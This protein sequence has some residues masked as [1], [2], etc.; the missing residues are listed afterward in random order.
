M[1]TQLAGCLVSLLVFAAAAPAAGQQ[2]DSA[3]LVTRL[4]DDTLAVERWIRTPTGIEAEVALRAPRTSYA[5]YRLFTTAG[6]V[7]M[8]WEGSVWGGAG[9]GEPQATERATLEGDTLVLVRTREGRTTTARIAAGPDVLPFIDMV[10]WPFELMLMRAHASGREEVTQP[11]VSGTRTAPFVLRRTGPDGISVTHP[12]RGTMTTR[13]DGQGR[14]R[15]LDAGQTTRAL[16]VSREP[17]LDVRAIATRFAAGDAAGRSFGEL[18][19]RG[20]GEFDLYQGT[21]TLDYGTPQKRG[22]DIWGALV[23][24]GRVWRTGANQATHLTTTEDLLFGDLLVPAGAYT[25][26]SIPEAT[27]GVLIINRQTGQNGQVYNADRDLGRVPFRTAPLPEPVESFTIRAEDRGDGPALRLLWDRTEYYVPIRQAADVQLA[28]FDLAWETVNRTH[29][30]TTFNGVNWAALRDSLRPRAAGA[31][32]DTIRALLQSMLNRLGQSHFSVLP[33]D[34][35]QARRSGGGMATIGVTVRLVGDAVT[36]TEVAP[37]AP[38]DRAGVRPGWIVTAVDTVRLAPLV[39]QARAR[40]GRYA[41]AVRVALV[42]QALLSGDPDSQVLV[43][44]RDA[45]DREVHHHFVR[46]A[47]TGQPVNFG[48]FPTFFAEFH[49]Q[50][51]DGPPSVVVLGFNNWMIPLM[52]QLDSTVVAAQPVDGVVIDLRGNTGGMAAMVMGVAGHFTERRDTLGLFRTRRQSL[53]YAANPRLTTPTG[54]RIRPYAGPVAILVDELS[55]SASEVFAGGMQALGRVR[56]FGKTTMGA[57]LPAQWQ[58]LPNGDVLYHAIADFITADGKVL[59]GVGVVPDQ[60]VPLTRAD[61]LAG[62]DP[63]LDAAIQWI[64]ARRSGTSQEGTR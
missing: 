10:H 62:R 2:A 57:V 49:G 58:K 61:L 4:G 9:Q 37:G 29:F 1:R 23:P 12:T 64:A 56:V 8:G 42:A 63:V 32:R 46:V 59:E 41:E 54:E 40:P 11:L 13:V 38:A 53:A 33:E 52:R 15:S 43:R 39:E 47:P 21:I 44:F 16:I 45:D 7:L 24:F 20:G 30:D 14:L 25:L 22:R 26:Y 5:R 31:P 35:L 19:G 6:G 28:S 48:D 60:P 51:L 3:A 34:M 18:S 36:V 55:G 50:R 27:G 17:W